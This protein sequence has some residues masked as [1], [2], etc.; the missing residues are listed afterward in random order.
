MRACVIAII[1]SALLAAP[2][3]PADSAAEQI[4]PL[5]NADTVVVGH[6]DL[7]KVDLDPLFQLVTAIAPE[8]QGPT[9]EMMHMAKATFQR[10]REA[11]LKDVFVLYATADFPNEPV[12]VIPADQANAFPLPLEGLLPSS[13]NH[14]ETIGNFVGLGRA[15]ALERLKTLRPAARPEL[16]EA[17]E[18]A[19]DVALRIAILPTADMRFAF[20]QVSPLLP[21]ELGGGSVRV[22][23]QDMG[24]MVF[25]VQTTDQLPI[26]GVLQ[27]TNE[28]SA[29]ALTRVVEKALAWVG[30]QPIAFMRKSIKEAY[31]DIYERGVELLTPTVA[32]AQVTL[33]VNAVPDLIDILRLF[34]RQ[35]IAK[36]QQSMNNLKQIGLA[37]HNYYDVHQRLPGNIVDADGNPLLSWRVQLLPYVEY[38]HLYKQFK[39]DEPWDSEHNKVLIAHM[40]KVFQSPAQSANLTT[41]TTY[42]APV[43][44]GTVFPPTGVVQF[45][46]IV[47]GTSNTIM[48][49]E[50]SDDA[51]VIWSQ[52]DDP[53]I[54]EVDL[55][56]LLLGHYQEG[57]IA[58]YCDGSV[59]FFPD[60]IDVQTLRALFTRNGGEV[61]N[62]P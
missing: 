45:Q 22:L 11:G 12:F 37:I 61:V 5:V 30:D 57:F 32:D 44:E 15:R 21:Q 56:K 10:V 27:T 28:A 18:E 43:G 29:K 6:L 35:P 60:S 58:L 31:P 53:L 2:A 42:V 59:R 40:P 1:L 41:K 23:T 34:E 13:A 33:E 39:L 25:S 55:P 7:S 8:G 4:A 47:D 26:R 52:P 62:I 48:V 38:D 9:P 19:G 51:A 17:F 54:E 3:Q 46:N 49:V 50:A 16:S 14:R 36:V 24:W 20:E